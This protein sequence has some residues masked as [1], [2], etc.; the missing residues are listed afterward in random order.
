MLVYIH[1]IFELLS[2]FVAIFYY[3]YLKGPFMKWFLPFLG[4]ICLG[5]FIANYQHSVRKESAIAINY[6]IGIVESIFYAYIFYHLN[7]SRL[8]KKVI[9]FFVSKSVVGYLVAYSFYRETLRY[10]SPVFMLSGFFLAAIALVNLYMK[11]A[12]TMKRF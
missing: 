7:H 4:F 5:K 12:M 8:L 11:F 9:V 6:L 1:N 3:R 10:F 2:F